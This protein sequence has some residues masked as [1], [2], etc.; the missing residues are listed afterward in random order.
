MARDITNAQK[1][2]NINDLIDYFVEGCKVKSDL[3]VG[4]EHEKILFNPD[5]LTPLPYEGDNG[6]AVILEK[7]ADK[8][9][10]QKIID[11][12][13][14]I[15]LYDPM[16][17]AA[18]S[19]EPGGQFE[20]SGAPLENIHQT[21]NE[22]KQH[23]VNLQ[24]VIQNMQVSILGMGAVPN[25]C[26]AN[27]PQMPKSRYN[28]MR[29][30]MP[31]VGTRGL[32][33]M[34]Q[35]CTIQAN[36]DYC[37]EEDMRNKMQISFKLQPLI[38]AIFAAS[39]F[40]CAIPNGLLSWRAAIW[41]DT[42]NVRCGILPCVFKENFGFEDYINWALDIPMYFILRDNKYHQATDITFRQF[43]NGA[44][45]NKIKDY[46]ANMGDWINHLGTLFPDVRL[47]QYIEVRGADFGSYEHICALPALWVGLLYDK[48]SLQQIT[49]L[50]KD[51]KLEEI[52]TLRDQ[53]PS[54]ALNVTFRKEKLK[55]IALKVLNIANLGLEKRSFINNKQQDET[56]YLQPL[57]D[58]V[59]NGETL[60]N[61]WRDN[62]YNEWN[63]DI[64]KVFNS[65][66][67]T[68]P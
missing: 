24:Q 18:I 37:S 54:R 64:N 65:A 31:Q 8:L 13:N 22:L 21:S 28:I 17:M 41:Q 5:N 6:I 51:W 16:T 36:L 67:I 50:T 49:D 42:D 40:N 7:M 2:S 44:M 53:V 4:T 34:H 9:K 10:W 30:Y 38:T 29:S 19:L 15:G 43:I 59:K 35:T 23:F 68:I 12:G 33:M 48:N 52:L 39:P 66:Y 25:V 3:K 27:L 26:L 60:A 46:H 45:K 63:L 61:K 1:I 32:N 57:Y 58:I 62:Y 11:N 56:I 14:L 55:D 20:L 47:K